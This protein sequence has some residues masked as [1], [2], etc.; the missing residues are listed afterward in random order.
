VAHRSGGPLKDIVLAD[1]TRGSIYFSL[2]DVPVLMSTG[3]LATTAEEYADCIYQVEA[4][5]LSDDILTRGRSSRGGTS[6]SACK[7]RPA[8]L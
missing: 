1:Q 5:H 3:Y 4:L 6:T 8:R 2:S 7:E